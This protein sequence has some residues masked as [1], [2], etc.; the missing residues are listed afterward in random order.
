MAPDSYDPSSVFENA[1][2]GDDVWRDGRN[3]AYER[4]IRN[5]PAHPVTVSRTIAPPLLFFRDRLDPTS[6][7][8]IDLSRPEAE[9]DDGVL[10]QSLTLQITTDEPSFDPIYQTMPW[11]RGLAAAGV[12]LDGSQIRYTNNL[13]NLIGAEALVRENFL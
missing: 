4:L 12:M 1:P 7:V 6:V 13:S 5:A 3:E 10:F 11:L 9:I 8:S 2:Q